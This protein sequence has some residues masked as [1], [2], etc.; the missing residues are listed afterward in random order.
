MS[1]VK[2][3]HI[4]LDTPDQIADYLAVRTAL[5]IRR[6]ADLLRKEARSPYLD[7]R[8]RDP[9]HRPLL[10][11]Q[12]RGAAPVAAAQPSLSRWL[13]DGPTDSHPPSDSYP[14]CLSFSGN[15]PLPIAIPD[16]RGRGQTSEVRS[17]ASQVGPDFQGFLDPTLTLSVL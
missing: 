4:N 3:L 7:S 2:Q 12:R 16:L 6:D 1:A 11:V 15:H 9:P 17:G 5:G 14:R 13:Y 10:R 8:L